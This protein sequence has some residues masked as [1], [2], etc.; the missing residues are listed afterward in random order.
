MSV[1]ES[2]PNTNSA[3][4]PILPEELDLLSRPDWI[5]LTKDSFP[6]GSFGHAYFPDLLEGR[7][8]PSTILDFPL[9]KLF[10]HNKPGALAELS[11]AGI[12]TC[13]DA[14]NQ[15]SVGLQSK[16]TDHLTGF[17]HD[18][19]VTPQG[20]LLAEV[21]GKPAIPVRFDQEMEF[22]A[23]VNDAVTVTLI[24]PENY[25][26][27]RHQAV[28]ALKRK[29]PVDRRYELWLL[30]VRLFGLIDG[31]ARTPT[32]VGKMIEFDIDDSAILAKKDRA[33]G[34]LIHSKI[35]GH[36]D[37]LAA[38]RKILESSSGKTP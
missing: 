10:K 1:V 6:A 32:E 7:R 5:P 4:I 24:L 29:S 19:T 35:D 9:A 17:L 28:G 18:L 14:L 26:L 20:R 8:R 21:T 23:A 15:P 37:P 3:P 16:L 22:V 12:H 25:Q 33:I 38:A 2:A 34:Q 27:S 13:A 30:M 36:N 11:A 31:I